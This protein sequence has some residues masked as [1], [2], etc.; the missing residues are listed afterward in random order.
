M[1]RILSQVIPLV[2]TPLLTRL[3]TPADFGIFATFLSL[4][5]II[6]LISNGRYNLA[7]TLPKKL[8]KATELVIVCL[9]GVVATSLFSLLLFLSFRTDIL[10]WLSLTGKDSLAFLIPIGIFIVASIESVY[11]WLLRR[12]DYKFLSKNFIIQTGVTTLLKLGFAFLYWG[13]FGLVFAYVLGAL[14]SLIL[15]VIRFLK[16]SDFIN[17]IKS[18]KRKDLLNTAREYREFPMLSMPADGINS[19]ANHLPNILLNSLFG[20]SIAGFYSVTHRVLGLPVSFISSAM[21]DV[22]RERASADFR[23]KGDSRKIFLAT[24]KYLTIFSIPIFVFLFLF[25]PTIVPFLLGN[26]WAEVGEYIRILTPLFFFRFIASPLSSTLYINKKQKHLLL[27]QIGLLV[28]T[29]ASFYIGN[30][31]GS[32]NLSLTIFSVSYSVMYVILIILGYKF[33]KK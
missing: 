3:Y 13:W 10:N 23:E 17:V 14:L 32:A 30:M 26:Q 28:C 5:T 6:S 19:F 2:V 22:Y 9:I 4:V 29:V 25:A 8:N 20:S 11:Y 31:L 15:L 16:N 18:I 12:R 27:W 21:T 1:G 33:T 7:I 24:L